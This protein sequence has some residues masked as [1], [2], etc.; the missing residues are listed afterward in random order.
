MRRWAFLA[1]LAVAGSATAQPGGRGPGG[2][3]GD[4]YADPAGVIQAEIA[5][6]QLA[7]EKGQWAALA[8]MAAKNAVLLVPHPVFA[9]G[10]LKGQKPVGSPARLNTHFVYLSCDGST[11]LSAGT[12][13]RPGGEKGWYRAV[14]RREPKKRTFQWVLATAGTL[15]RAGEEPDSISARV[16]RCAKR[17]PEGRKEAAAVPSLD[18]KQ[19]LPADHEERSADGSLRW[20]WSGD[21]VL[22]GWMAGEGG[23]VKV[24]PAGAGLP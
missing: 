24:L 1:L 7:G 22:E 13:S 12:W 3:G 17:G 15:E 8:R 6:G 2:E 4:S 16:A 18:P 19:P 5:V 21:G 23:E 11:A 20:R 9:E 14:W 10:W